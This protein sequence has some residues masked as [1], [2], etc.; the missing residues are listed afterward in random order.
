M[1]AKAKSPLRPAPTFSAPLATRGPVV[2][3]GALGPTGTPVGAGAPGV[4]GASGTSGVGVGGVPGTAVTVTTGMV[5][6]PGV[7]IAVVTGPTVK[8]VGAGQ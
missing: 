8:V 6:V 4:I 2:A 7:G 1:A 3:G 5:Y